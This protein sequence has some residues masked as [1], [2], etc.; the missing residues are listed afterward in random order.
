M[1]TSSKAVKSIQVAA[2]VLGSK[3]QSYSPRTLIWAHFH[4]ITTAT[5]GNRTFKFELHDAAGNILW[6]VVSGANQ[7]ASLTRHYN[8]MP[9]VVRESTF[10]G[11]NELVMP[12]P[13]LVLMPGQYITVTDIN[14]IDAA[15]TFEMNYQAV[16]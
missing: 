13:P 5:A 16:E 14:S 8:L 1:S 2:A 3:V 11:G 9:G 4:C 15:D 12:M 6:D 7:A 10:S